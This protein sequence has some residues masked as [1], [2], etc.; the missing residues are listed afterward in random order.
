MVDHGKRKGDNAC[1]GN[2]RVVRDGSHALLQRQ[3]VPRDG[4]QIIFHFAIVGQTNRTQA[5]IGAQ[6][7]ARPQLLGG[8]GMGRDVESQQHVLVA[9]ITGNGLR[10]RFTASKV[11]VAIEVD[12][13][14]ENGGATGRVDYGCRDDRGLAGDK[15]GQHNAIFVVAIGVIAIGAGGRL[16]VEFAV[17][18]CAQA[19]SVNNDV[20]GAIAAQQ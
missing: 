16:T 8:V 3:V 13:A 11:A 7:E 18:A 17:L 20:A 5:G 10:Y 15:G 6:A 9:S 2:Q 14:I 19:Q 4:D 1:A 12:K